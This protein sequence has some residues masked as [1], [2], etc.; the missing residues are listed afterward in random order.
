M[1]FFFQIF[2]RFLFLGRCA[3]LF[4]PSLSIFSWSSKTLAFV[5]HGFL[6][7]FKFSF[8]HYF[9]PGAQ[10]FCF[11]V[12]ALFFRSGFHKDRYNCA[13]VLFLLETHGVQKCVVVTGVCMHLCTHNMLPQYTHS[14]YTQQEWRWRWWWRKRRLLRIMWTCV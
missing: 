3:I 4:I 2:I 8:S 13:Q 10:C 6:F 11:A 5:Y 7:S 14:I 12:L 9:F 1:F